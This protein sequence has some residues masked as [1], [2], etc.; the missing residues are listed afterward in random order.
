MAEKIVFI[1]T[2]NTCRSPMAEGFFRMLDGPARTGFMPESAGL[3][4]VN[5]L[6]ASENAVIAAKEKGADIGAHQAQML[7]DTLVNQAAYLAC[8]TGAHYDRVTDLFPKAAEKVFTL[9]EQDISDPFGGNL[10]TYRRAAD[11]IY[12]AVAS[13]IERLEAGR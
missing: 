8:M 7:T 5:G 11:E 3:Y 10:D 12:Q 2:G 4:T 13:V 9:A 6:P 1:C